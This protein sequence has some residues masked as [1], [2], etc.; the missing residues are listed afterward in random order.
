MSTGEPGAG[1]PGALGHSQGRC[2]ESG[3]FSVLATE[4]LASASL[5]LGKLKSRTR[6]DSAVKAAYMIRWRPRRAV[7]QRRREAMLIESSS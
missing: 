4:L 7:E 2:C 5:S 1:G 3:R 6:A